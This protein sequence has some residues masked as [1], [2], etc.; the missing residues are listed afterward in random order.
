MLARAGL[1][2]A[3]V[4]VLHGCGRVPAEPAAGEWRTFEGSWSAVGTRRAIP[5]AGGG[6]AATV[7]LSGAVVLR[8]GDGLGRGFRGEAI[9]FDDGQALRAGRWVWTD[10]R[11][12]QVF[13]EATG[14]PLRSGRRLQATITGGSGRYAGITGEFSFIWQ[15]VVAEDA[16]AFHLRT[17]TI[18]GRYRRGGA[19]P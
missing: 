12:D 5:T 16:E 18:E 4:P 3:L 9:G 10:D 13:G 2:L 1:L 8:S 17:T 19:Q 14:E 15:E 7:H 6:S 11:G